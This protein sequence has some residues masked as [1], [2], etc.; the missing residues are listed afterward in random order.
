M[1]KI[2][3]LKRKPNNTR[4][5]ES[6]YAGSKRKLGAFIGQ[7]GVIET[8]LTPEEEEKLL[9]SVLNVRVDSLEYLKRKEEFYGNL[10]VDIPLQGAPLQI[11][12]DKKGNY[13]KVTDYIKYKF[14]MVHPW[15]ADKEENI[16][17]QNHKQFY[18]HNPE[19]E[20]VIKAEKLNSRKNAYKEFI[21]LSADKEKMLMV[22]NLLGVNPLIL[23]PEEVE[24]MLEETAQTKPD[25]FM[26]VVKD[27]NLETKAFITQ[28]ISAEVLTKSGN[29]IL[30]GDQVLGNSMEDVIGYLN[31]KANS[32]TL[33]R[34]R[35]R[36]QQF[37]K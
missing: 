30:E 12:T 1:S 14:A 31:D 7:H 2:V 15:V 27:K 29:S 36:L 28:C 21:K 37:S 19:K 11:G 9:P 3:Y 8:G 24:F 35:A 20:L 5:P 16:M 23:E 13:L 4:L 33:A 22:A 25:K 6:V 17:G 34:L 18:I 32:D 10:T 26:A